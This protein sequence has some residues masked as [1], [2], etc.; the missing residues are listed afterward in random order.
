MDSSEKG[1]YN[2]DTVANSLEITTHHIGISTQSTK[3]VQLGHAATNH[4]HSK[5]HHDTMDSVADNKACKLPKYN[6]KQVSYLLLGA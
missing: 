4:F 3:H 5:R 2:T 6:H 1:L